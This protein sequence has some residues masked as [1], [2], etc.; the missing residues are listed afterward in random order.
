MYFFSLT[1][2]HS[3]N[4]SLGP[5]RILQLQPITNRQAVGIRHRY[6]PTI[7]TIMGEPAT[8]IFKISNQERQIPLARTFASLAFSLQYF[9]LIPPQYHHQLLNQSTGTLFLF[10]RTGERER[11]VSALLSSLSKYSYL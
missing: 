2:N 9:N 4:S 10:S 3:H 5:V 1:H 8:A 11:R 7:I 6:Y